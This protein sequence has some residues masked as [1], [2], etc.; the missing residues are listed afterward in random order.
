MGLLMPLLAGAW[1]AG[2][3]MLPL[4]AGTAR[5]TPFQDGFIATGLTTAAVAVLALCA[6]L[7]LGLRGSPGEP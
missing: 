5:G 1:G 7:L 3:A 6:L 4:A 2:S